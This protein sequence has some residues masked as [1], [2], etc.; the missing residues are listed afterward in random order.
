MLS[1]YHIFPNKKFPKSSQVWRGTAL[2]LKQILTVFATIIYKAFNTVTASWFVRPLRTFQ[3][4]Q[5]SRTLGSFFLSKEETELIVSKPAFEKSSLFKC[6][7]RHN[8]LCCYNSFMIKKLD[9]WPTTCT[10]SHCKKPLHE[11]FN[12]FQS[13]NRS[14]RKFKFTGVWILWSRQ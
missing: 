12:V 7:M 13:S 1:I 4:T 2:F 9:L 8:R 11:M 6:S 5:L 10:C 14:R 3:S